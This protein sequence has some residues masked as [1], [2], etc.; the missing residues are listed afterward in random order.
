MVELE[1]G[2]EGRVD[3]GL[4]GED[5]DGPG[6]PELKSSARPWSISASVSL[7]TP[8]PLAWARSGFRVAVSASGNFFG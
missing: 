7:S 3:K 6:I 8:L 1:L 4:E 5:E 2:L